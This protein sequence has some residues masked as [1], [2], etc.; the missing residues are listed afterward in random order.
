MLRIPGW[1][2]GATVAI[3]GEE[4]AGVKPGEF[5]RVARTWKT[6]LSSS[7]SYRAPP[8]VPESWSAWVRTVLSTF[9]RSSVELTATAT[10]KQFLG[11]TETEPVQPIFRDFSASARATMLDGQTLVMSGSQKQSV[12]ELP[13]DAKQIFVLVT[14]TL[15]DPGG[16]R[17][18]VRNDEQ[19]ESAISPQP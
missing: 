5:F 10:V 3:N 19:P 7:Y 11:Y 9:W 14:P 1:A 12:G 17:L 4:Q 15:I 6:S 13:A 8:S 16:N 2:A 18:H